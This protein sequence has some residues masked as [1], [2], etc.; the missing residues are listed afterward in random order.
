MNIVQNLM[1]RLRPLVG[2]KGWDYCILWKLSEDQRFL[3]W[4]DCCC[5]GV[6]DTPNGGEEFQFPLSPILQ[7]R[8]VMF[9][10]PRTKSCEL[11]AQVPSSVA[12]DSGIHAQTLITNQP[13]WLNFSCIS[14]STVMEDAVGTRVLIPVAGGLIELFVSEDP[15]VIDFVI[16][17]CT[18][19][20][21]QEA[22]ISSSNMDTS[23]A[24]NELQPKPFLGEE[25]DQQ[26]NGNSHFQAPISPATALETIPYDISI[27]RIRLCNS[28]V[29]FLQQCSY[30][31]EHK[32]KSD[33]F[34]EGSHPFKSS[35]D[36][37]TQEMDALQKSMHMQF[38]EPLANKEQDSIKQENGR[39][40]SRSDCSDQIDD[41]D[42]ARD[43]RR[44]RTGPQC[45]NLVAERKRRKKLNDRLY[46]L[47]SL[48]P[49]ISK[50]DRASILG[51]AIE[52]VMELQKQAKE[53][54]DELENHSDDDGTKNMGINGNRN[55]LQSEA[56]NQ[57]GISIDPKSE[58]GKISNGFHVASS[59]NESISKQNQ[60]PEITIEKGQ[61]M[62]VQVEVAQIDGNEFFVNVFCEHKTGGFVKLMEALNSL[63]L[64]VTHANMTSFRGLVSNV[65]KVR[66]KD[67]EIVQADHV[68]ES[69][70]ELTR[71]QPRGWPEIGIAS[72][73]IDGDMDYHYHQHH[74]NNQHIN[75]H[76]NHIHH[77]HN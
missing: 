12:L 6:E 24:M 31:P 41:E 21:E 58:Y 9:Q 30:T 16:A 33:I 72:E 65:L 44:N 61:Q 64:E 74:L 53:L 56:L 13:R 27:D 68:R 60:E 39:S 55:N 2:L 32:I 51:D 34:F 54:Q 47:R 70:L 17:Q 42:D 35:K 10:H 29:N 59:G 19:S 26:E 50:L 8:D 76:H 38:M 69:L 7:C 23:Y 57:N 62:E 37:G 5:A 71:D 22:M 28:P 46:T 49:K 3:E 14:D 25:N 77:F 11:L 4:M 43:R 52:F 45:K 63:G 1:E 20:M 73:S 66:K 18:T 15:H 48:V 67:S 40:E 36:N 75:A